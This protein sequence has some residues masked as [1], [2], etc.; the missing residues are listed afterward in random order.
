MANNEDPNC[1]FIIRHYQVSDMKGRVIKRGL[2]LD[3]AQAHCSDPETSSSTCR[4]NAGQA[5][6]QR[7]GAWF[8]GY[9]Q[10]T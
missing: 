5:R 4:N 8:D 6:T 3:E 1:Y 7:V 2:T 10:A 9:E